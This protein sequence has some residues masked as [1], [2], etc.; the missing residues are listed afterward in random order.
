MQPAG[1]M[2][3]SWARLSYS[4]GLDRSDSQGYFQVQI[5]MA[6]K[7]MG[8]DAY[9]ID[10]EPH[11]QGEDIGWSLACERAGLQLAWDGRVASKHVMD[12]RQLHR[13]DPRVGY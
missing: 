13:R 4:Q 7:M 2:A 12:P 3:P 6:I 5:I 11:A 9:A 8:P 10:Y 1:T